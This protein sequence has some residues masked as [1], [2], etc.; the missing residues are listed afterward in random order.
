MRKANQR[1]LYSLTGTLYS[2]VYTLFSSLTFRWFFDAYG[3][4]ILPGF[5][6]VSFRAL[7]SDISTAF[8]P[9]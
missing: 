6:I 4:W 9:F 8:R 3:F 2:A 1:Q 5:W 7:S